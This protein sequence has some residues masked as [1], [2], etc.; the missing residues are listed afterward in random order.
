MRKPDLYAQIM[1]AKEKKIPDVNFITPK[2]T[3]VKL[4]WTKNEYRA[5]KAAHGG[6]MDMKLGSTIA[7]PLQAYIEKN[8]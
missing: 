1:G 7:E 2:G 3:Q 6:W 5:W 8:F 4:I